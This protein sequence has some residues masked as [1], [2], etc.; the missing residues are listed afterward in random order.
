MR[1][2]GLKYEIS[3]KS[4]EMKFTKRM[5]KYG[6]MKKRI[7]RERNVKITVYAKQCLLTA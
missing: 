6:I 4:F 3:K 5:E 2:S 1:I 7:E